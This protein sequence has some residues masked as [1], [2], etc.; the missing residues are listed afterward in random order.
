[1]TKFLLSTACASALLA[2]AAPALAEEAPAPDPDV[3]GR[4]A[5]AGVDTLVVTATRSPQRI[6]RIGQ[7]VT[8]L[9][10]EA[11]QASQ[12]AVISDLL[13]MTPGV[14]FSRNGGVG[15]TTSL[16]IRG[17]ETDQTVV[18]VDGV[19]LNDPTSP[20][21]GYNFA[22]MLAGDIAR[23]E[24][25]RGAQSTLWGSQAIGGVVNI[26]TA[27]PTKPFEGSA[28]LEGGSMSTGYARAAVGGASERLVWRLAG[29]YYT[30]RG[31]SAF[32]GGSE[33]DGYRNTG[34]SGRL[35][36][37]V[38]DDVTVDLR[39]VY[40][41]GRNQFD[42]FPPPNF[43]F[44]DDN[45]YGT[46]EEFVGYAG[47]NF[48]LL[49]GRLKNRIA[50]GYTNT[51]R[52]NYNPDQE[53]TPITFTANGKNERWEYQG[54]FA[55]TDDWNAVFGLESERST[56][57]SA[58][59]SAF[60]PNPPRI[61]GKVGIDSAYLQLQGQVI[62]GLTVTAGLRYDDHDTFGDRTLGQLAAAWSL[63]DGATV[64]RASW[65]QGFKA[66]TLYQLYSPY[67]NT[68][69]KPEEADGWDMG[70][71]QHLAD[72]KLTL[73]ATYFHR[74]TTNQIDFAYCTGAP[75]PL[76]AAGGGVRFGYY[77]NVAK[78]RAQGVELSG[79]LRPDDRWTLRANYT[80]T[81]AANE[82]P[83]ANNGKALAR[84]PENAGS[85][86]VAYLW[87]A[88][89]TTTLSARYNGDTYDDVANKYLLKNYTL[90]DVAASYPVNDRLEVYGRVENLFDQSNQTVRN[91]G[92]PGRGAYLGVRA[93]F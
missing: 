9:D 15:A 57:R 79:E 24:V 36:Y 70:V 25:L 73:Q 40:S 38:S 26:V 89:L 67:G 32:A 75:D 61:N 52:N 28:S 2:L 44:A 85:A 72:G 4:A 53:V 18:V 65:G 81:D 31:V 42:G 39:A 19:K 68:T 55:V 48:A 82:A 88:K 60:A 33:A 47:V 1:M 8:V 64:L 66:P 90:V 58:S 3:A 34:F 74:D 84:R 49:D 43:V 45:E 77:S 46:T 30:T 10:A 23:I 50:Y 29:G 71:E 17:A 93:R 56:M 14:S 83:G 86:S 78:T 22:N 87:P 12:K 63:N 20:G 35:R 76:C 21:G 11:I 91:Y 27:D 51:N 6:D 59:P 80:W 16:R 62:R 37:K 69:L 7:S 13:A 54:T 5:A 92:S 41:K